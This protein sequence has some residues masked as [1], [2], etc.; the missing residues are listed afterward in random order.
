MKSS[1]WRV[2]KLSEGLIQPG[3]F[4]WEEAEVPPLGPG[5]VQV[6]TLYLS[7]DP[8]S[9]IWLQ[10]RDTYVPGLKV[11]EI[12]RGFAIG[13][14]LDSRH[15][16]FQ[17]GAYVLGMLG[18]QTVPVVDGSGLMQLPPPEEVP[19]AAQFGLLGHIGL[20]AHYGMLEIGKPKPGETVVVSTAAG[21]VGSL[22]VQLAKLAG[23]RVVGIAG[24]TEKCDWVV[25]ELRADACINYKTEDLDQALAR[26]CPQGVDVY[27]D[28]VGGATLDIL[29]GR[30]KNFGRIIECGMVSE[31]NAK[32]RV[33]TARNMFDVVTKRLLIKGFVCTDHLDSAEKAYRELM[34]WHQEG[35]IRY[36]VDEVQGLSNAPSAMLRLFD[37]SHR[38]KLVVK[39][40]D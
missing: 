1:C 16:G 7:L 21:A 18:W 27:F 38:G 25:H 2:V 29:L 14:V 30:M 31:Y 28:N 32:E 34:K 15:P 26:H 6:Q 24:S 22:A 4:R 17:K 39:V 36:R 33:F 11:G 19:F 35:K 5:Q 23:A 13:R 20:T 9:R 37:G 10:D 3:D 8:G 40:A 12:M